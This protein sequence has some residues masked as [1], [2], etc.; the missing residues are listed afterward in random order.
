[1]SE[2][3]IYLVRHTEIYNPNKLCFGQ[4]EIPLEENF[5]VSFD[6]ISDHLALSENA[7]FYTSPLRRCTKLSDYLS[8]GNSQADARIIELNF[9]AWEMKSWEEIPEKEIAQWKDDFV[10]YHIKNG[11]S[12]NDLNDRAISFYQ[13]ICEKENE[14][15]VVIVT[16]ASVIRSIISYVLDFPLEKIFN[17]QVDYSSI[18]GLSYNDGISKLNFSNLTA[19]LY[20]IEQ[21]D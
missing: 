14:E 20:K 21:K 18:S 15:D 2:K 16:H 6:W 5:T 19:S 7:S 8:N 11:E 13:E 17:V 3:K 1:M 12:F 4:S 9:G 10:N